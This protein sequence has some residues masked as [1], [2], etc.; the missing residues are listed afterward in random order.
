MNEAF[1]YE[2]YWW[3][4]GADQNSVP[5]TL[6]FDPGKGASLDLMGSLKGLEGVV[7]PFEPGIIQ[8]LSSDGKLV[9]LKDCGRT[10]GSL[11]FGSGFATSAFATGIVFV[12]EHFERP[13]DAGFERLVVEYL[14]LDAWADASGFDIS[15]HE[16]TGEPNKR[17]IEMRHE[18][19]ESSSS[20]V[21]DG[22]DVS[23]DFGSNFEASQRPFTW[24]TINQPAEL[25]IRFPEKQ[26]FDRLS[27]IVFR[28]QHLLSLGMR[29]SAYPEAQS[30]RCCRR[31][32]DVCRR[33]ARLE[34]G[35]NGEAGGERVAAH[36]A[37]DLA[38]VRLRV[39]WIVSACYREQAKETL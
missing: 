14:H 4:P 2:G 23:L 36:D 22:Y 34:R 38:K 1:R 25:T 26:P 12:G 3:L 29:R 7:D 33:A 35:D 24:A 9:T 31:G 28:L 19:L 16:E 30:S 15:F 11:R 5:G 37:V 32:W 27:G 17:W 8:G 6:K 18:L 20:T 21:G 13:E 10:L 39:L